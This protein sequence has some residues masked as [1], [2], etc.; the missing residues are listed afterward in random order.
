MSAKKLSKALLMMFFSLCYTDNSYALEFLPQPK[1]ISLNYD[2][3]IIVDSW[4][5]LELPSDFKNKFSVAIAEFHKTISVFPKNDSKII[6]SANVTN[7]ISHDLLPKH[8]SEA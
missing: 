5:T 6:I 1:K 3:K 7:K 2:K 4:A 8:I